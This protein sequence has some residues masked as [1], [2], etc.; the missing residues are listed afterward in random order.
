MEVSQARF[1][2]GAL[3]DTPQPVPSGTRRSGGATRGQ[4]AMRAMLEWP[5]GLCRAERDD[6]S[7]HLLAIG[8]VDFEPA[9]QRRRPAGGR[10]SG[11]KAVR[12]MAEW[13]DPVGSAGAGVH[14]PH[15]GE[16]V[17]VQPGAGR[18]REL[19]IG[20]EVIVPR[21]RRVALDIAAQILRGIGN[22]SG[23]T[24]SPRRP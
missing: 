3:T 6:H 19:H 12:P 17:T 21:A 15:R 7:L 24:I 14:R 11:E 2:V 13:Q 1:R 10:T 20:R 4:A 5:L 23:G 18:A 22:R 8:L 16:I 9:A